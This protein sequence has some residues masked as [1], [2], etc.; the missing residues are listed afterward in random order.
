MTLLPQDPRVRNPILFGI[1]ALLIVITG[2]SQGP[3]TALLL[4]NMGLVSA[5]MAIGVN[6]Q[7]GYAGLFNIGIMGFVALGGLAVVVTSMPPIG[8]AWAAGGF[9]VIGGLIFE[10]LTIVG[11]ILLYARMTPG[12]SRAWTMV[13][14]LVVGF[15]AYRWI[16]D[17]AAIGAFGSSSPRHAFQKGVNTL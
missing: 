10:A 12:R 11:A 9:R 2:Y 17:G 6:L 15:F 13:G 16:F 14:V 1:V 4:V 7:W 3:N 5:I 8:A